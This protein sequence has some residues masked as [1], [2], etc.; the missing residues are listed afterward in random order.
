MGC[1]VDVVVAAVLFVLVG[2]GAHEAHSSHGSFSVHLTTVP[3]LIYVGLV[4][5]Y[6]FGVSRP[7]RRGR[8]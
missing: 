8:R 2:I 7:A 3:T 1:L 5:A 4:L 6:W